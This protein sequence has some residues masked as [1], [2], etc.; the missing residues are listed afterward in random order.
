MPTA[1]LSAAAAILTPSNAWKSRP[2]RGGPRRGSGV[3]PARGRRRLCSEQPGRGRPDTKRKTAATR[4]HAYPPP[5]PPR[6]KGGEGRKRRR[7]E[8]CYERKHHRAKSR[9]GR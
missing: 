1:T 6:R 8:R 7:R 2:R 5:P 4:S 9:G 3:G